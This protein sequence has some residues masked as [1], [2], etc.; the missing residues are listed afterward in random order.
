M[1]KNPKI[2]DRVEQYKRKKGISYINA[3]STFFKTSKVFLCIFFAWAIVM[4]LLT[5]LS[6]SLKI[7]TE[8]FKYVSISFYTILIVSLLSIAGF[9]L[10]FTRKKLIGVIISPVASILTIIAYAPLLK[11][12]TMKLGYKTIFFTRH[13]IPHAGITVF[14][15]IMLFTL[16]IYHFKSNV[17]YKKLE[18]TIYEEY[19]AKKEK[20]N[21]NITWEEYL[22]TI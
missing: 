9:V 19:T 13:L 15:L 1:K 12:A 5:V 4:N 8:G 20:D 2:L 14:S 21:L 17:L 7:G 11:D 10:V 18:K 16:L 3:D 22:N 6:W